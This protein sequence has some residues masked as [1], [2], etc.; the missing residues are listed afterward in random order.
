MSA[1]TVNAA[2]MAFKKALIE[3]ALGAELTY[4]LGYLPC[5][6]KSD[7]D[8]NHGNGISAKTVL[9][10]DGRLRIQVPRDHAG[11]HPL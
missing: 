6:G 11:T 7:N 4:Y 8:A 9:N 5:A 10:E 1:E 3:Q 2:S